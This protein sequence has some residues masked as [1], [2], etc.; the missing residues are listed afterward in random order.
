MDTFSKQLRTQSS[1][2]C[3]NL[4]AWV[5]QYAERRIN[6]LLIDT[7]RSI[8][9]HIVLDFGNV[10]LLGLQVPQ[11]CG[12]LELSYRDLVTVL[13][14][15]A[16]IDL[17][18][19]TFVAVHN[20][21]GIRPIMR[22]A[23]DDN[24]EKWLS[25]LASGRILGA[26]A[27]T[28]PAA[29]SNPNGMEAVVTLAPSGER[30][31]NA[32]KMWIGSAG[33]AGLI[34][35][36]ARN[37]DETGKPRGT[38]AY[39]VPAESVGLKIGPE[40]LTMGM[41]GMVQNL[42][43]FQDVVVADAQ[44]LGRDGEGLA[45]AHDAMMHT[46]FALGA[47]FL[48]A[49]KRCFQI[50][51]RYAERRAGICAGKLVDNPVSRE[52]LSIVAAQIDALEQAL[53]IATDLFDKGRMP[54]EEL[55][56]VIKACGSEFLWRA[57]DWTIQMLGGRGY[58]ESNI[59]TQIMRDARVGRIFEGPTE[60]LLHH[61]G[62]RVM[63]S[64]ENLFG[65]L[66]ES[67]DA[68]DIVDRLREAKHILKAQSPDCAPDYPGRQ[69]RDLASYRL[70]DLTAKGLLYAVMRISSDAGLGEWSKDW[71]AAEFQTALEDLTK[72]KRVAAL[73]AQALVKLDQRYKLAIGDIEQ[74]L[75]A[76][77]WRLDP[78][79]RKKDNP[80]YQMTW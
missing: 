21:L 30:V 16:A 73:S 33:W 53:A 43:V 7:R 71:A 51:M 35:V 9:P 46:R 37:I 68:K 56:V 48:G 25:S 31:L 79:L 38:S 5:R 64:E 18:L 76:E 52:R 6:S 14:Q 41:R 1:A 4:L 36:F 65:F 66:E 28:E 60:T 3:L 27:L 26:F 2:T 74:A 12:G 63:I 8:P 67:L 22:G 69:A 15:L 44:R 61:V 39:V 19:G 80:P 75:P 23:Q 17:S 62:A 49:M 70:G 34:N 55:L 24:R 32:T 72:T 13:E 11:H 10:G 20:C 42:V 50:M 77:E 78:Y 47:L 57:A 29:G 58:I 59:V 40:L 45:V 54:P